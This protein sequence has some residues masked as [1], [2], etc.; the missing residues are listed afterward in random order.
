LLVIHIQKHVPDKKKG[1]KCPL[2]GRNR[3]WIELP[4]FHGFGCSSCG[5]LFTSFGEFVGKSLHEMKENLDNHLR[6]HPK[7]ANEGHLKTGQR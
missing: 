1:V 5:W 6:D 3:I 7:P 4:N 2:M